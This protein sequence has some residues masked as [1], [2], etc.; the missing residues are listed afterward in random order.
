MTD[1]VPGWLT[2]PHLMRVL[3]ENAADTAP[4]SASH[5]DDSLL[6]AYSRAVAGAAE[7]VSPA[8]AFIEIKKNLRAREGSREMA[9]S[10]SGFVFTP[11]G[12]IV[13]NSHVV[14]GASE[15]RVTLP[16]GRHYSAALVGDDP[17]TDLAVIRIDA[18]KLPSVTFGESRHIR[19]GQL[20]IAIG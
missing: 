15:V 13:T 10:G 5:G 3:G 20:A 1:P 19:V 2:P 6:D 14:S 4:G 12:L 17:D 18:D 7:R 16:D 9:G 11:D 8:V